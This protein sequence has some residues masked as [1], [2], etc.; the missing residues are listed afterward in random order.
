MRVDFL[1]E[2]SQAMG[3]LD[4][5]SI[6]QNACQIET[7]ESR[8][9]YVQQACGGNRVLLSRVEALLRV[10]DGNPDFLESPAEELRGA[11]QI[12]VSEGVGSQIGLYRLVELIGEGGFGVVFMAEQR[13]PVRRTVAL[14]ILKPGMGTRQVVAR[15][16]AERQALALMDHPNLAH[17]LD[18][19]QTPTGRPYFVMDLV[20]GVPITSYC[21]E[22]QLTPR[23][24]LTLFIPVCR[25]IQHAHQKGIIHRDLKPTNVL[26]AAYDGQPVPKVIDF[27]VAKA[28]GQPLTER[29]LVTGFGGIVGTL[30][31]MSPEQA[32][33][34]ARDVDTRAD[35]YSLGVLLYELL[36]GTTPLTKE[37]LRESATPEVLRLI[38][39]EEPPKPSTRLSALCRFPPPLGTRTSEESG[40]APGTHPSLASISAQR[41]LE[42]TGLTRELR[43]ELDWI[44]MKALEKDRDR[45]YQ[46]ANGLARDIQRYLNDE[47]VEACPPSAGYKLRK[48]THTYR[49][50]LSV[51]GA[52]AIL[53][54]AGTL[55]SLW[56][57]IRATQAEYATG[58]ERDRA[59][60]EAKRAQRHVY[61]AHM[62]LAL[63][64]YEGARMK[65]VME[66]LELHRPPL[67][68]EDLRGFEWHYLKR[69]T[70]TPLFTLKGHRGLVSRVAFSPD[71]K[72]LASAGEDGQIKMWDLASGRCFPEFEGHKQWAT[73][74][75]FSPDGKQL[76]S[77]S[78]DGTLKLWDAVSGR[79][80]RTLDGHNKKWV[81]SVAFSPDGKRLASGASDHTV[82]L[83][84]PTDGR[85]TQTLTGHTH[86]VVS[87]AF[88]PDKKH[89]ASGS[90]DRTVMIWD[91]AVEHPPVAL[92]GHTDSVASVAFSPD[93][94][95]LASAGADRK[96][97]LWDV[98]SGSCI[99]TL[100]GHTD[101][102]YAVA[103][104]PDG[105]KLAS[106]SWDQTIR[107]WDPDSGEE[108]MSLKGHTSWIAGIAFSPDGAHL[109]SASHDETV[110]VWDTTI[111]EDAAIVI[112]ESN[113]LKCVVFSPDGERL[114]ST[115]HDPRIMI[116]DAGSS[117]ELRTFYGHTGVVFGLAY[118]PSGDRLASV[119]QDKTVKLWDAN[120]GRVIRTLKGPTEGFSRLGCIVALARTGNAWPPAAKTTV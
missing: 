20:K 98:A 60:A 56:Q 99:R 105:K 115:G 5:A 33:F 111:G 57:A 75:A 28:M 18:G 19:G 97:K 67:G 73:S 85:V 50:F 53:L 43:G 21:D 16:E 89:L 66:L 83:W 109:A 118:D 14:K 27:G 103:F 110:K 26:I 38:R 9:E 113:V 46:T 54:T 34:N 58:T 117:R 65:R 95:R 101:R 40:S 36:T 37:R 63:S 88:S 52:F 31:Y 49:K 119:S 82:K 77:A 116:R 120:S 10:F 15:F 69:L 25:A 24:R 1:F 51:A 64:A 47:P 62:N 71:G 23:E 92:R 114:A 17:V 76:A 41:K 112:K 87:L 8:R 96:V 35:I 106:G 79:K 104:S 48:F 108:M 3:N 11:G 86:H 90:H 45:R 29:T 84:D 4:E 22:H 55:V 39:E 6:F 72:K 61:A 78:Y 91:L 7:A 2:N 13:Q 30:E 100:W 68:E 74:V 94:R 107:M 44:V 102:V 81:V 59:E 42:P 12:V 80:I 93:G 32:E 70:D